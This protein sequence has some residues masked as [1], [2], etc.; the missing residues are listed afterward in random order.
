MRWAA[1]GVALVV[2]ATI[3]AAAPREPPRA[4]VGAQSAAVSAPSEVRSFRSVRSYVAVA[5]P[6]RL[7]IADAGVD[8]P[9]QRLGRAPDGSIEVPTDFAMAGWFAE[10][11]RPGE[12]G[13][14]VV[15]GHVDSRRGPAVFYRLAR[16]TVGADVVVDRADGST[17]GFRVSRVLRVP[18]ADFPTALVYAP[19][20]E[21]SLRLVTCGGS[22]DRA[23]RS[24]LDNVI[25]YA[26]PV[27]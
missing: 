21:P 3:T 6:I 26:D 22:F 10:G 14:A 24:Y 12:P 20:L 1:A 7:R 9:L 17:V 23:R 19:T 13:P 25:V 18:K 27:A 15:L 8:T 2:F 16:L 11:V 4:T 5:E